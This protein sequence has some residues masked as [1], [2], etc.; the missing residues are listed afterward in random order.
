MPKLIK[1]KKVKVMKKVVSVLIIVLAFTAAVFAQS[2][3][4]QKSSADLQAIKNSPAYAEVLLKRVALEAE[5]EDLLVAYTEDFP[6]VKKLRFKLDLINKSLE[7]ILSV[8]PS[9]AGKLSAAL[10]KLIVQKVEYEAELAALRKEYEDDYP[11]VKRA[12]RK[13]EVYQNAINEI[14]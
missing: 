13:V 12:K 6:K 5:I 8:K 10:G 7:K 3:P 2:K 9:E 4:M 14:L 1:V 11:D